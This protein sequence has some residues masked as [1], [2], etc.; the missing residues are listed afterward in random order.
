MEIWWC[1]WGL[2]LVKWKQ[3]TKSGYEDKGGGGQ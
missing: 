1:W 3:R 2:V